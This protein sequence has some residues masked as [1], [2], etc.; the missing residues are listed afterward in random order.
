MNLRIHRQQLEGELGKKR[1]EIGEM[2]RLKTQQQELHTKQE[3][4][5][6][7]LLKEVET[8]SQLRENKAT[9]ADSLAKSSSEYLMEI[10]SGKRQLIIQQSEYESLKKS[11][12]AQIDSLG[13][14]KD[15]LVKELDKEH[16][17]RIASDEA[18]REKQIQIARQLDQIGLLEK[19][20]T[21]R[22]TH[23]RGLES[24]LQEETNAKIKA[25]KTLEQ[26]E[27]EIL[28]QNSLLAETKK[29]YSI[30]KNERERDYS[31]KYR[32]ETEPLK[33]RIQ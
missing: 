17:F 25:E 8:L 14:I 6:R 24:Q 7:E 27:T 1:H 11:Y 32:M 19:E 31:I 16:Q 33:K 4:T 18:S 12:L 22:A 29:S 10:H 9:E 2:L 3:T 21:T 26:L 15:Q 5:I 23:I 28:K 20:S 30:E 13:K